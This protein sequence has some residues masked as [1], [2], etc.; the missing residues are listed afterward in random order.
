MPYNDYGSWLRRR[1]PFRVQKIGVD[2]GLSCPNRDGTLGHGGCIYCN[3]SSFSPA[4]CRPSVPVARQLEEGK[5]FFARKYPAMRYI[6]YFQAYSNT[7]G[8]TPLL[9]KLY[10]EALEVPDVVGL[11]IATRPDC[12]SSS[13][14]NLLER[15]NRETFLIVEFGVESTCD[16]TLQLVRRGHTF[17]Q[18]QEAIR[19]THERGIL[20]GAHFIIGLPGEDA[21]LSVAQVD[22]I[23]ALP[24]DILK[25]HQLQVVRGS[26]LEAMYEQE[27]FPLYGVD[28]YIE[29]VCRILQRLRPDIIV[30]RFVSQAPASMLVAPRWGI[31]NHEFTHR[32]CHALLSRGARQGMLCDGLCPSRGAGDRSGSPLRR[33]LSQ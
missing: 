18:A 30:E 6:A 1:F 20:T 22:A 3:N 31:K 33:L 4:Y 12:L 15:L 8:P 17:Q 10:R 23:N 5:A 32:L 25:L 7:Y 9:E 19:Q 26:R 13:T 14:L 21:D 2:A 27:P 28:E 24:I 16:A 29:V 11:V